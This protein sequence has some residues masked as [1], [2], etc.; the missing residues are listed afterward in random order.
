MVPD[1]VGRLAVRDLPRHRA[2]LQVDRGDPPVGRLHQRK[3]LHGERNRRRLR[4][5]G[6]RG[7]AADVAHVRLLAAGDEAEVRDAG[8]GE[9]IEDTG[10][11]IEG[12][13]LPV[14][15]AGHV[16]QHQGGERA[17]PLAHHR[18][19]E[20]RPELEARRQLQPLGLQLRREVD[21]IV[22]A[23]T[24][25][26]E[27]GWLGDEELCRVRDLTRHIRRLD[28]ALLERPD[29]LAG[30][31][32]EHVQP[33][34]LGRLHDDLARPA[35]DRDV[36][37]DRR[38]RQ[39]P[40]PDPVLDELEVPLALAG[41]QIDGHQALAVEPGAW[42]MAAVVVAGRH[43]DRQVHQP[44]L[45]VGAHLRPHAG[46][47]RVLLGAALPGVVAEFAGA[48]NRVENPQPLARPHVVAAHVAL[49][50]AAAHRTAALGV[51]RADDHDVLD[52]DRRRVQTDVPGNRVHVLVVL[53][54]QID[55]PAFAEVGH[56]G[57]RLRVEPDH[58][59]PRCDVDDPLH[60][61]VGPVRQTASGKAARRL[62]SALALGLTMDPQR[63]AGCGVH[64]HDRASRP[65]G[66][67]QHA[68][69]HQRRG[70]EV[71]LGR[72]AEVVGLEAPRHFERVE[73]AGVDL[74]ERRIPRA[75]EIGA[76]GA[77]LGFHRGSFGRRR[78]PSGALR[79]RRRAENARG[80]P[81]HDQRADR[82][83]AARS[84]RRNRPDPP[85]RGHITP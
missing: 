27:S 50:V 11:G 18:G 26:L 43:L 19:R 63:L 53:E 76:V 29:R 65:G 24:L 69:D 5:L 6:I 14:G 83:H 54:L 13:P 81:R 34:L 30:H 49:V 47:A 42:P 39:V 17:I 10:L 2:A 75:R 56:Q 82:R 38:A 70:L 85:H 74:I 60:A 55:A 57:S 77:P 21:E 35:V 33:A 9:D 72:G 22:G 41:P 25:A 62:F 71:E 23:Y 64:G 8:V 73:V 78:R 31:A 68:P 16:G 32:V 4:V 66:G 7:L 80:E 79:E 1:V 46:V 59:V 67:V 28:L 44:E 84:R 51:R 40:V 45:L 3:A 37:Q 48:G 58:L 20:Q 52:D 61:A 12:A 15:A 36:G